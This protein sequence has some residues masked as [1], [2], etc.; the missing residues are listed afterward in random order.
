[1]AHYVAPAPLS[2]PPTSPVKWTALQE[3]AINKE[4]PIPQPSSSELPNDYVLRT[5]LQFLWLPEVRPTQSTPLVMLCVV[6]GAL[7]HYGS[8]L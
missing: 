1:M 4:Y 7:T 3:R 5:Y 2:L 8:T 6:S